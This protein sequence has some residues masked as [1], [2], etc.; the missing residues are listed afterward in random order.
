MNVVLVHGLWHAP[1]HFDLVTAGL[2]AAG[3]HVST[4]T[5][6]RGSLTADT[7]AVQAAVDEMPTPPVVLGHSYGGSVITGLTR[8]AHLVYLA[9]FVPD[10]GESAAGLGGPDPMVDAV[11]RR[12]P[13][14]L[15]EVDP[16]LAAQAL[17]AD[18]SPERAAWACAL[19]RPQAPGHGRGV[20]G[21]IAWRTTPSTYVVCRQDRALDP[22]V[23]RRM[24]RRC[25][26]VR[27]WAT[28]HSPFIS[29]PDLVVD[30]LIELEPGHD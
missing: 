28:S 14:G 13:D 10:H 9:A 5:L 3:V 17:Y 4:P 25:T 11:V 30:L 7:T 15:S 21:R 22:A 27:E 8:A 23:Q 1:A 6:H 24:A 16:D 19:L 2:R 18:C 29:R 20:P 26:Q 12:R